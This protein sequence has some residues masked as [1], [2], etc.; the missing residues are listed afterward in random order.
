VLAVN[1]VDSGKMRVYRAVA[2]PWQR[3][4]MPVTKKV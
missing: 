4:Y 3:Q 1:F 2:Q